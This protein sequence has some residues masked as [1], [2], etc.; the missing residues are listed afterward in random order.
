MS[1]KSI[2]IIEED[3]NSV[4]EIKKELAKLNLGFEVQTAKNGAEGLQVL[5]NSKKLHLPDLILLNLN[6]PVMNG[7]EFLRITK[8]YHTLKHIR[9]YV[10]SA[11][12][13]EYE[14]LLVMNSGADGYITKP[15]HFFEQGSQNKY[16]NSLKAELGV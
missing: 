6:M 11:A 5:T 9:I 14:K 13:D 3:T 12:F 2:L 15:L 16:V 10:I 4:Q 1:A 8:S 7:F